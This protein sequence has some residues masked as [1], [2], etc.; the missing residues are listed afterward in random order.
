MISKAALI[1]VLVSF[2]GCSTHQYTY[3]GKGP[4]RNTVGIRP[5]L[6]KTNHFFFGGLMQTITLDI[7]EVCER[8]DNTVQIESR[9][10]WLDILFTGGTMGIYSPTTTSV[11]CRY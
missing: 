11:Y 4:D 3:I 1:V 9:K 5:D 2:V 8:G 10:S 7:V 6:E